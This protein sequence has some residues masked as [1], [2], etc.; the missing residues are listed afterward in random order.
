MSDLD[1]RSAWADFWTAPGAGGCLA[2]VDA[3]FERAEAALWRPFAAAL[4]R[5]ARVVD[6]GTGDGV[7]LKR[8]LKL[9]PDL[10][11]VGV[12]SAPHLPAAPRGIT[13]KADVAAEDL[14]FADA[15]FD[16]AVSRYGYEYGET[17]RCALEMARVIKPGGRL[18]FIVHHRGGPV[19]AWNERRSAALR[20]AA[21]DSGYLAKARSYSA[22]RTIARLPVPADLL[23][24]PREAARR[25]PP[26]PVAGEVLTAMLQAIDPRLPPLQSGQALDLLERKAAG[27]LARLTALSAA[28]RDADGIGAITAELSEA[29]LAMEPPAPVAGRGG[30]PIAW[31]V[32]GVRRAA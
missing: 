22:A 32:T 24:A 8:L 27:E 6:I 9:R 15:G 26:D 18:L 25:Y 23:D 13:L 21:I 30:Q 16:A 11:L 17:A 1:P 4:P 12:D 28:A 3:D 31:R 29:G 5:K 10:K 2:G 14:P 20:W 19:V 7:V